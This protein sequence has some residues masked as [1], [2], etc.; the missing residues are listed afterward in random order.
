MGS[1]IMRPSFVEGQILAAAALQGTVDHA[2]AQQ[3]RHERYLHLWGIAAGLAL[4]KQDKSD[5]NNKAYVEVTLGKG[6]AIDGTGREVVVPDDAPLDENAFD[7]SN[8]AI[9][10]QP[11]AW[12]PV[13]L[14]GSDQNAAAAAGTPCGNSAGGGVTEAFSIAFGRPGD[15]ADLDS[16]AGPALGDAPGTGAWRVLIGFVQW[17][18][19]RTKFTAI[20]TSD[21][22]VSL[23]Y[24]GVQA[25]AVE[26]RAGALVLRS[27]PLAQAGPAIVM[28]NTEGGQ[29]K[30]G[31]QNASGLFTPVITFT[32]QGQITG[33]I[34]PGSVQVQSGTA[35][36][37]VVLP[38]PPGVTEQ[39]VAPDS[40]ALHVQLVPRLGALPPSGFTAT[41]PVS[42]SL[43][44]SI[45]Q[46][47]RVSCVVRWYDLTN[48]T[49][50]QDAAGI[51]DYLLVVA[52]P[53][54]SGGS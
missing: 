1:P 29:L 41:A 54:G 44:C 15:A 49:K 12:F 2:V 46:S 52:A 25:D 34:K 5:A 21:A 24:A 19:S 38:L 31:L 28:D 30:F 26:A 45:N 27:Q 7:N 40:G 20:G 4:T 10:A 23:R 8:V 48:P 9:G 50:T 33:G 39:M 47:R 22:G 35:S 32:A 13:F 37:G 43:D 3:A 51:C 36:D 11:G 53:A 42:F 6:V 16:Q 18:D 17:D 14:V